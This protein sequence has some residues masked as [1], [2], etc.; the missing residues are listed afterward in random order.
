[1]AKSNKS[2]KSFVFRSTIFK[3]VGGAL[4]NPGESR[5]CKVGKHKV[6]V[7]RAERLDP[8]GNPIHTAAVIR[9]DGTVGKAAKTNGGA[10]MAV[11]EALENV[12]VGTKYAKRR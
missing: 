6:L 1:M 8:Y 4:S 9:K 3:S 7:T 5:V 10:T 11:S 2:T 12:G